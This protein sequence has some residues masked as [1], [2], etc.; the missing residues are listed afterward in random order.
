[1]NKTITIRDVAEKAGVSVSAVHIA[2]NDKKGVSEEKRSLIKR[3]AS[4]LGY[5]PNT[6]ASIL[7]QRRKTVVILLPSEEGD[8]QYFFPQIW[9]GIHDMMQRQKT[10]FA[11]LEFPYSK[12][13]CEEIR[14]KIVAL[15]HRNEIDG[16]L[17]VGYQDVLREEDWD[18]LEKLGTRIVLIHSEKPG[19]D[20]FCCIEP[21]YEVIG[22]TM[23]ELITSHITDYGSIF[24]AAGN[25]KFSSHSLVVRGFEKYLKENHIQNM[26][27]RD[28]FWTMDEVNYIHILREISRPDVAACC[29]VFSQGTILLGRALEESGKANKLFSLGTDLS[30]ETVQRV[31][32]G[33][34]DNVIQKNPYAEGYLGLDVL[35]DYFLN[36][37]QAER[38]IYVGADVVF[39][40]NIEMYQNKNYTALLLG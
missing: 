36:G 20:V 17:T 26:I 11:Y 1:M 21:N 16:L 22:R 31:K 33:V 15:I 24:I 29:A 19:R 13:N 34:F 18:R 37:N 38:K 30:V 35:V 6:M 12:D 7:K 8:N 28:F 27:Y 10:N 23:A 39:R 4:E 14:E 2:L 25:P 32:T 3:I 5:Q 9:Q 40:S